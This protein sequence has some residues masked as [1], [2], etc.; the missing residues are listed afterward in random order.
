[1]IL[2]RRLKYC[3]YRMK[4][5]HVLDPFTHRWTRR[6]VRNGNPEWRDRKYLHVFLEDGTD[7]VG[8][9]WK[10]ICGRFHHEAGRV[11]TPEDVARGIH[12]FIIEPYK[13]AI[14]LGWLLKHENSVMTAARLS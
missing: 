11:Q 6:R 3:V 12:I 10:S 5:E 7:S 1:M 9:R 4:T 2:L 14:C 8:Q 13:C